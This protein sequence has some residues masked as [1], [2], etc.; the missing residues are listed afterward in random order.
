MI[1]RSGFIS[2]FRTSS[3]RRLFSEFFK[4]LLHK[5]NFELKNLSTITHI[6]KMCLLLFV[7]CISVFL[8]FLVCWNNFVHYSVGWGC[9][10]HRLN[11]CRRSR[12]YP[13]ECP[14]YDTKQSDCEVPVMPELWGTQSIPSL[15]LFPGQIRTA[16]VV[17]NSVLSMG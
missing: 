2:S 1:F 9:R 14:A 6:I 13:N 3:R 11:L 7:S 17:L 10:I 5:H 8:L 12:L 15:P 16:V 4:E